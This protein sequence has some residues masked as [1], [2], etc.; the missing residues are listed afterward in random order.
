MPYIKMNLP[1]VYLCSPYWT[2]LPPPSPYHF[3]SL[4]NES[5]FLYFQFF[6]KKNWPHLTHQLQILK[7]LQF[8]VNGSF[9][10][11]MAIRTLTWVCHLQVPEAMQ[12]KCK[13]GGRDF[14]NCK[15]CYKCVEL[16]LQIKLMCC[17]RG[18][19]DEDQEL[20]VFRNTLNLSILKILFFRRNL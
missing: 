5:T 9:T 13:Y 17:A 14:T 20:G 3:I 12:M 6:S 19:H 11:G 18:K 8:L 15:T 10:R 4:K 2:L 7:F 16:W 1:Q